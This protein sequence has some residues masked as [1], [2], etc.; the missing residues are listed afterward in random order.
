MT[1]KEYQVSSDQYQKKL[2]P[3]IERIGINENNDN[4]DG[5]NGFFRYHSIRT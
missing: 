4:M 2:E 5:T 1:N 3:K